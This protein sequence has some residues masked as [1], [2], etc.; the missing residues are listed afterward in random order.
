L[1]KVVI[2][3][4]RPIFFSQHGIYIWN[5]IE[6]S[7][8]DLYE[9]DSFDYIPFEEIANV[10]CDGPRLTINHNMSFDLYTSVL[11]NFIAEKI[12]SLTSTPLAKRGNE[13]NYYLTK[14]NDLNELKKVA[15]NSDKLLSG[16]EILSAILF[17]NIF[18]LIPAGIYFE[19][20]FQIKFS[21]ILAISIYFLV[22]ILSFWHLQRKSKLSLNSVGL[23]VHL[24]LY[25]VSAIHVVQSLTR[26]SLTSF[27]F[28]AV[29][30]YFLGADDFRKILKKELKRIHFSKLKCDDKELTACIELNEN[31]LHQ[32]LPKAGLVIEDLFE[33][34][35]K[36]DFNAAGYCPLCEVEYIEGVKIC[37]DCDIRLTV[38]R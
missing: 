37:P 8:F 5:K 2:A 25:P 33:Q 28:V 12:L 36:G 31:F 9:S 23:L 4:T 3:A 11:S 15:P 38:Y 1:C 27:N 22:I 35:R 20:A 16:L 17:V 13:I 7:D 18:A 21:L 24:L 26:H 29:S 34:P 10:E 32:F 6:L 19:R 14:D 30:A